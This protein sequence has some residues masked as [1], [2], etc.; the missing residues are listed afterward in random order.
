MKPTQLKNAMSKDIMSFQQYRIRFAAG[1]ST[2]KRLFKELSDLYAKLDCESNATPMSSYCHA[3]L[4]SSYYL[5]I[6]TSS[7]KD[8]ELVQ[9][10]Q[11][12]R[13]DTAICNF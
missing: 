7:E 12:Y 5:A 13:A 6:L 2:R 8:T 3:D 9:R 10:H 11:K 4:R 1:E